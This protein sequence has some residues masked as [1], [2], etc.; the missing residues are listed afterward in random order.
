VNGKF[1][2]LPGQ[3]VGQRGDALLDLRLA[4]RDEGQPQGVRLRMFGIE[5]APGTNAKPRSTACGSRAIES[6]PSRS[7]TQKNMPPSG[8]VQS[9]PGG[10][11]R[12][13]AA[14]IA[15]RRDR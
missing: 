1:I 2:G 14:R 8:T 15:S 12:S 7:S 11:W 6:T 9:Q 10:I 5:A 3:A 13:S 4:D